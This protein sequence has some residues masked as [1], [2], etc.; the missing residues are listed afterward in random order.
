MKKQIVIAESEKLISGLVALLNYFVLESIKH[1]DNLFNYSRTYNVKSNINKVNQFLEIINFE[2]LI[3][4][5]RERNSFNEIPIVELYYNLIKASTN[6]EEEKI[7]FP[8]KGI[9]FSMFRT[10]RYK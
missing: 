8:F 7:L 1:N 2:N 9:C 6:F 3:Q 4:Y 5:L 10:P